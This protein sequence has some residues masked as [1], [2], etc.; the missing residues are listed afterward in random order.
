MNQ[1]IN[2][3]TYKRLQVLHYIMGAAHI[4]E[5]IH[6]VGEFQSITALLNR[7]K[8]SQKFPFCIEL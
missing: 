4:A 7:T 5:Q 8:N 1:Q 6:P 2:K 3:Q